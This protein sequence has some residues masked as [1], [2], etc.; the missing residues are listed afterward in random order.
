MLQKYISFNKE[1]VIYLF[2]TYD[3]LVYNNENL[4]T[5]WNGFLYLVLGLCENLIMLIR[6]LVTVLVT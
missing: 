2:H 4:I 5:H 1:T 3:L 6:L